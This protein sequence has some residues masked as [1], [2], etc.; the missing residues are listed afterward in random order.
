MRRTPSCGGR[1]TS[2]ARLGLPDH[3][4]VPCQPRIQLRE[5][6]SNHLVDQLHHTGT[7]VRGCDEV[8]TRLDAVERIRDGNGAL[9]RGQKSVV[10]LGIT[11]ADDVMRG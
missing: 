4:V 9:A 2:V 6:G 8:C 10:V 5:V 1:R 3:E 7:V 11:D